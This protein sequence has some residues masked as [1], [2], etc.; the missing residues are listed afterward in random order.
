M[1]TPD[2]REVFL[3]RAAARDRLVQSGDMTL[4]E[5]FDGLVSAMFDIPAWLLDAHDDD[6]AQQADRRV[7]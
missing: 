3:A 4:S 5:A 2:P 6:L 7:A 1:S